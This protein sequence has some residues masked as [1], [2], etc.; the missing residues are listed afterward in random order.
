MAKSQGSGKSTARRYSPEE[1]AAAVRMLRTLRAELGTEHGTVHRVASQLG[2][3][4]E[5][6]RAWVRQADVDDG[7]SPGVSTSEARRVRELEQENRELRRANGIL[8]RAAKFLR[9][10][11]RP[12]TSEIVSFIDANKEDVVEGRRLGVEPIC[13]LLQVAPSTYYAAKNRAPSARAVSDAVLTPDLIRLWEDN[14]RVYG[15]RKLWK[16]ACRAGIDIGRDQTG[17]LMRAAGI[18]GARRSKRVRTTRPDPAAR[19]HPDLVNREFTAVA[20]NRLWVTDLTFVPTWAGVAY[21]C[22]IIDV[23]SRMIVGWR[24]ASHMRTEMVLDAIEMARWGRGTHHD[25]LRCHSD[26]GSQFTPIR[27]GERLAEIGATPSIRTVG[28]S[29]DNALAETVNGYY[30]TE[31]VRGPV[32]P[33]PWRTVEDLELATLGWVH[34][35][36]TERLHGY[37]GDIPPAEFEQTFHAGKTNNTKLV[38]IK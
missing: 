14:Y 35:H 13:T 36:N 24:C 26:A 30:K 16:A 20:P 5:S 9:G 3:G 17:R 37:L 7:Q 18:E 19:R 34:W 4:T 15:V 29:Y 32:R 6:V 2:Y 23:F 25:D 38:E 8:K 27:Y 1:K 33:G 31:L 11:A 12:P 21:V 28:D 22:F 10:G